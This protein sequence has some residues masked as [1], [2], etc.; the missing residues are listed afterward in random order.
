[1][2]TY[3][4]IYSRMKQKYIEESG[5]DF[6]EASDI[7]IRLRVLAG[8][9]YN[10]QNSLDWLKRQMFVT[11]ASGE[12]LDYLASER[13]LTRKSATKAAGKITFSL[14][15]AIDHAVTIPVG[16][17]VSTNDEVPIRF[18]TTSS[19]VIKAGGGAITVKAEAEL[20]GNSGNI[21]AGKASV[22]VSVPAEIARV[23][24][25]STFSGGTD[26]ESDDELRERIKNSFISQA[27]GA[28][29]AYYEQLALTVDGVAKAGVLSKARGAGTVNV[30]VC[31]ANAAVSDSTLA[32]VQSLLNE[33]RELVTDVKAMKATFVPYD[34]LVTVT[35]K[36]GY[37]TSEVK[38]ACTNAFVSYINSLPIGAKLYLSALGKCLLET[39]CIENYEFDI[40]MQNQTIS[41]SQCFQKGTVTIEVE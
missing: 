14:S 9:I 29:A 7:G 16:A 12:S 34:M 25:S 41:A 21:S 20:A 39:G 36:T 40:T 31:G 8:E 5:D 10:M 28:N 4:S 11:T 33:K 3:E 27:N 13:G 2:E 35:A 38:T 22:P 30:Y 23:N 24:N 32:E 26:K 6:L 19:G 37:S 18:Y 17:V 15:G 1:M